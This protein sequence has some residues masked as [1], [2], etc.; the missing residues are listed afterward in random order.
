VAALAAEGEVDVGG[1][2]R[3]RWEGGGGGGGRGIPTN[4]WWARRDWGRFPPVWELEDER[5]G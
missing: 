5:E 1:S 4:R 3:E 2:W